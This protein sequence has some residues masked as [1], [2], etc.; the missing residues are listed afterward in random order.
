MV[1]T[2]G[3]WDAPSFGKQREQASFSASMKGNRQRQQHVKGDA[4]K[5]YLGTR[6]EKI[7]SWVSVALGLV[8]KHLRDIAGIYAHRESTGM[9]IYLHLPMCERLCDKLNM[10]ALRIFIFQKLCLDIVT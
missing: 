1:K 8:M 3:L 7:G 10:G 9:F 2:P 6:E 4:G 5:G